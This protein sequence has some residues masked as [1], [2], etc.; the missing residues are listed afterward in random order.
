V[1]DY[2]NG[3]PIWKPIETAYVHWDSSG[4]GWGAVLNDCVEAK[5]F[6]GMPDLEEHITFKELKAVRYA[7]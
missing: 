1:P 6:W 4:Y 7:I 5:G 3:S 2:K